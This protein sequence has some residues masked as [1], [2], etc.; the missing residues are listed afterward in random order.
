MLLSEILC[1]GELTALFVVLLV[2]AWICT[3]PLD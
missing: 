2:L 1:W 3:V